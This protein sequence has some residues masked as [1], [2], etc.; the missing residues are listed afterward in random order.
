MPTKKLKI[1]MLTWEIMPMYA[2]GLGLLARSVVDELRRSGSEVTVLVPLIPK[3]LHIP[4]VISLEKKVIKFNKQK[5][6]IPGSD[7]SL[8][9]FKKTNKIGS[10]NWP[11]L[12]EKKST[13]IV[14]SY[15]LYPNNTPSLTRAFAFAVQDFLKINNGWD[16]ILG[17][18]WESVATFQLLKSL[19][20]TVPF[21]FY[22]N[23]T[24]YDRNLDKKKLDNITKTIWGLEQ[25]NFLKAD[26]LFSVSE[27]TKQILVNKYDVPESKITPVFNDL[28]FSPTKSVYKSLS[29][30]KKVLFIGRLSTQKGLF[31]LIDT[32]QKVL[33]IDPYIQFIVA[34]DGEILSQAIELSCQKEI[35]KNIIFTGWATDSEKKKLYRSCDLFVMPSPSEPFGLTALESVRSDLPV[36]ASENCG[37]L[38]IMPSTPTFQYYD[39]NQFAHLIL[40]YLN[41]PKKKQDLLEKQKKDLQKHFWNEE[42][43][44]IN[45]KIRSFK[46]AKDIL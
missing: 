35:E 14:S 24:E 41:D 28:H 16:A 25:E 17:M 29:Y 44:K 3:G 1:L 36:I 43:A 45:N 20:S 6:K 32:A 30:G 22:V 26:F 4:D 9:L 8:D 10:Y 15:N 37:F 19:E 5:L 31:F 18:D 33:E 11:K 27:I 38:G 13:K 21:G 7:F 39:T 42:V 40:H 23:A 34:G 12:F 46:T 2:G